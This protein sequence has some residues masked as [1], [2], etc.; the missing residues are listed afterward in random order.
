MDLHTWTNGVGGAGRLRVPTSWSVGFSA[1]PTGAWV[2]TDHVFLIY[3]RHIVKSCFLTMAVLKAWT[4]ECVCVCIH[5]HIYM[6]M[7]E[8]Q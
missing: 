8:G 1:D 4:Y 7:A 3:Y 6:S 5:T 2:L